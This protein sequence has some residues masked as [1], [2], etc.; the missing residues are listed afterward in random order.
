MFGKYRERR[1]PL[2]YWIIG[3]FTLAIEIMLGINAAFLVDSVLQ[4]MIDNMLSGTQWSALSPTIALLLGLGFGFCLT[5]GGLWTFAG[6][7]DNMEDAKA[8]IDAS[9]ASWFSMAALIGLA[10]LIM[11]LDLFTLFFRMDYFKEHGATPL[12]WFFVILI[13]M[14]MLLGYLMYVLSNVPQYR[15]EA[16]AKAAATRLSTADLQHAI[17]NMDPDL[18]NRFANDDKTALTEHYERIETA[19]TADREREREKLQVK[20]D[21]KREKREKQERRRN[22][23]R[24]VGPN[25]QADGT[26]LSA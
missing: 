9:G 19:R 13:P 4:V 20:E 1:Y 21:K 7:V 25:S 14:P 24:L 26:D 15:Y 17:E 22:P 3:L 2:A 11:G 18:R 16:R 12:F 6:F 23:F 5:V 8:Y 10:V